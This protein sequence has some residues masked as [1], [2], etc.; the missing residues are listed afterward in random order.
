MMRFLILLTLLS[1]SL[2]TQAARH[3]FCSDSWRV[4]HRVVMVGDDI[5]R[6]VKAIDK[7]HNIDWLR[8]GPN[9]KKWT[10]VRS[11]YNAKT[12]QIQVENGR[13]QRICQY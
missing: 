7:A 3:K 1:C 8:G 2:N 9:S 13:L 10:L 4:G 5:G 12:V 6:A 11:G